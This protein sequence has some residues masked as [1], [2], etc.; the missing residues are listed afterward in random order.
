MI[1]QRSS[2]LQD[3]LTHTRQSFFGRI[4][5]LFSGGDIT[6]ETW[7]ELEALLIAADVG[8]ATTME[9]VD[10]LR[11]RVAREHIYRADEAQA[12]LKQQMISLLQANAH[13]YL[14]GGGRPLS[15]VLVIGVNGSGKTTSIAKLARYHQ[16]RGDKV[17]LAAGDT[18]RAAAIDQL[19][20]WAK[21]LGVELVAHQPG[22]DPGAVLYDAIYAAQARGANVLIADTAGRLHTK[23]NLM[24]ELKKIHH[25]AARQ[26]PGAPHETVLVLDATTGQN[27]LAQART[28]SEA[29]RVTGLFLAKL[30]GTAKGGIVFAVARELGIPILF[31]GTGEQAEDIAEFDAI[32]FVDG[33]FR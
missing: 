27:G 20:V 25:V 13:Y 22:S 9:L 19:A 29:V 16:L 17:L 15:I 8:V 4:A 14:E 2:K 33:L 18:F 32:Q 28:F 26:L 31:V 10:A 24:Q 30:D 23:H 21:R 5:G 12:L 1:F 3:S 11:E 6:E 7:E